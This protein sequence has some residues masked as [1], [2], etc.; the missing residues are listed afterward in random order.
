MEDFTGQGLDDLAKRVARTP[1]AARQTFTDDPLRVLRCVRFSAR[2]GLTMDDEVILAIQDEDIR[3]SLQSKV[4]RERI[5][6]EITK[7][8]D[9]APKASLDHLMSLGLYSTVFGAGKQEQSVLD[10]AEILEHLDDV[11]SIHWLAAAVSPFGSD[12]K[13]VIST[14][15]KVSFAL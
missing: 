1:L 7:M 13:D 15:L 6:I 4:S 3:R 2:Y 9:K 11:E 8:L 10:Y 5:G 12:A 14:Y